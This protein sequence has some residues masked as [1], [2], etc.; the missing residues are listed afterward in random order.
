M[1][2]NSYTPDGRP[3][4]RSVITCL[5]AIVGCALLAVVALVVAYF[6]IRVLNPSTSNIPSILSGGSVRL[7]PV[8]IDAKDA[9]QLE[10]SVGN[11]T[12][13]IAPSKDLAGRDVV[14]VIESYGKGEG[15]HP[16]ATCT[17]EGGVLRIVQKSEEGAFESWGQRIIEV[18]V[19]PSVMERLEVVSLEGMSGE[20]IATDL[21]CEQLHVDIASGS[22]TL[23]DAQADHLQLTLSSGGADL[24][25]TFDDVDVSVGSGGANLYVTGEPTRITCDV[26]S[27][28]LDVS[29]PR[30]LGFT[31][32]TKVGAGEMTFEQKVVEE[33]SNVAVF[34]DGRTE[35]H[36]SVGSGSL[37]VSEH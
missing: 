13:T 14:R 19:S 35:M 2:P 27:G 37:H 28:G 36:L 4:A 24:S 20:V 30:K 15:D 26:T 29:L 3:G 11:A 7:D 8:T 9:T 5:T 6:L 17:L 1:R 10:V 16:L 22:I 32:W 33:G 31:A 21:D 18:E 12:L 34:G 25:G 23:R